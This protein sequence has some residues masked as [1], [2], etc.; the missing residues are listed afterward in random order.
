MSTL[1]QTWIAKSDGMYSR[2]RITRF[3]ND[4]DSLVYGTY[5][6]DASTTGVLPGVARTNFNSPS[7]SDKVELTTP[8]MTY[9]NFNFYGDIEVKAANN[10]F[11]NCYFYGGL[12]HP[13]AQR[14]CVY[15]QGNNN[16][17]GAEFYDCTFRARF[18]S[19]FRDC[20]IGNSYK[21]F[22]CDLSNTT[23]GA[24]A[25]S[26]PG[27]GGN[28]DVEIYG[29][30]IHDLIWWRQDPAQTDGSHN[31]CIQFQGGSHF[32]AKGNNLEGY[33]IT[34]EGSTDTNKRIAP[35]GKCYIGSG[36]IINQTT[37]IASDILIEDNWFYGCYSQLQ[38]NRNGIGALTLAL[39][40]NLFG[41]DIYI[42]SPNSNPNRRWI[43]LVPNGGT[44][45]VTNLLT[46]QRFE[47]TNA[48]LT[49]GLNSGIQTRT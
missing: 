5:K 45:N 14:G 13:K 17:N 49:H 39:G 28:C 41:R 24:G 27:G 32:I 33:C 16:H 7:T 20:I 11:I 21:L 44:V 23:D 2:G 36:I 38:L 12:D 9:E 1:V 37:H 8:D 34:A 29:C 35:N 42:N 25:Y 10:I 43:E 30:Y 3:T 26:A 19:W 15:L 46:H 31:D 48:L 22:R 6:P 47:D 4:R 40:N 18:P